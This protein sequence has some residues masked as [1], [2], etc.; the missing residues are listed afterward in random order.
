MNRW[1]IEMG[2]TF[3]T[4]KKDINT[5]SY[6]LGELG[7]ETLMLIAQGCVNDGELLQLSALKQSC[8]E[9]KIPLLETLGL[10]KI[11]NGEYSTT[12]Y[13]NKVLL[14]FNGWKQ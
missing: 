11:N 14:K 3:T 5:I 8:L 10:I 6:L 9:I 7:L 13:G 1:L 2:K 12:E 4:S